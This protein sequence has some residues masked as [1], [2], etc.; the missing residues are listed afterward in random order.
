MVAITDDHGGADV[1]RRL[2]AGGLRATRRAHAISCVLRVGKVHQTSLVA[3]RVP[4][5]LFDDFAHR[6]QL[7][8]RGSRGS[9]DDHGVGDVCA[10]RI[11]DWARGTRGADARNSSKRFLGDAFP[12][13]GLVR[14]WETEKRIRFRPFLDIVVVILENVVPIIARFRERAK[15]GDDVRH[16]VAVGERAR[17]QSRRVRRVRARAQSH[18]GTGGRRD[19]VPDQSADVHRAHRPTPRDGPEGDQRPHRHRASA[20]IIARA[21]SPARRRPSHRIGVLAPTRSN[22]A[23]RCTRFGPVRR[24][25][26]PRSSRRRVPSARLVSPWTWNPRR[27]SAVVDGHARGRVCDGDG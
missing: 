17:Y 25:V 4:H 27:Q 22:D 12:L 20:S 24:R 15:L 21:S 7:G 6:F 13:V 11:R 9:R 5:R 3:H 8:V 23:R 10:E 16:L 19:V 26:F 2:G 14:S 18:P 1:P